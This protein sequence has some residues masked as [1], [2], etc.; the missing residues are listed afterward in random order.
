MLERGSF[1]IKQRFAEI[2]GHDLD[3][4]RAAE[5]FGNDPLGTW[6]GVLTELVH[7]PMYADAA[8]LRLFALALADDP[9]IRVALQRQISR[10]LV[11]GRAHVRAQPGGRHRPHRRRPGRRRLAAPPPSPSS[12]R[13]AS[14][15]RA[16]T[17]CT[18]CPT[19][20][21][22][23]WRSCARR[24][25]TSTSRKDRPREPH[26]GPRE[27]P[28]HV[29]DALR[30]V[31]RAVHDHARQHGRERRAAVHPARPR[32]DPVDA[33]V[34]G[35][36]LRPDLRHADP[37]RRQA[38]RP[39]RPQ[40]AVPRRPDRSSPSRRRLRPLRHRHP[41]DRRPRRSRASARRS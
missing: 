10:Q 27:R 30:D 19:S 39:L 38:R 1:C 16:R 6:A 23:S 3:P 5:T 36:R 37:A 13:C 31:F 4:D 20:S 40:A 14:P 9:E 32:R 8:R 21:R 29:V 25:L 22:R 7:E 33:R 15:S 12:R 41:A 18:T 17:A 34:D 35:Q 28:P 26:Q 2:L 11:D 24:A